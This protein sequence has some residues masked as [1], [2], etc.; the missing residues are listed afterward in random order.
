MDIILERILQ[1]MQIEKIKKTEL[2]DSLGFSSS[3]I[4]GHWLSGRNT[5]YK[6]I[7]SRYS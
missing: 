4:F 7:Y 3:A 2:T 5:S 6:K 1:E